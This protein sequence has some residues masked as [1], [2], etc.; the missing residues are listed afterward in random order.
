MCIKVQ[1]RCSQCVCKK[2]LFKLLA[3]LFCAV[4]ICADL[5]S[6]TAQY[7]KEIHVYCILFA[8]GL[9]WAFR[10]HYLPFGVHVGIELGLLWCQSFS[11]WWLVR[12]HYLLTERK[13]LVSKNT[14]GLSQAACREG[15]NVSNSFVDWRIS[16]HSERI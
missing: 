2:K 16:E 15:H 7:C 11:L 3:G 14:E 8:L 12:C 1:S 5:D 13:G 4:S 10:P 9:E 6:S